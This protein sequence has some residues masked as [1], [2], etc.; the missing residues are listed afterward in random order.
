MT[1]TNRHQF[2]GQPLDW[3]FPLTF[4]HEGIP[5]GNATFG[6]LMWGEDSQVRITVNRADYWD[7]RGGITWS[8]EA[9]FTNLRH[10]LETDD[11]TNLR[12]VFEG[13]RTGAETD[14]P[15]P[16]RLPMGRVDL[17]LPEGAALTLGQLD[18]GT[19]EATLQAGAAQVDA[20][21]MR[22]DPVLALRIAAEDVQVKSVP[23]DAPEVVEHF[24]KYGFPPAQVED[25]DDYGCWTQECPGEPVMC[26]GWL[27]R[28]VEEGLEVLI[29]SV[30]G[31]TVEEA[32]QIA[33]ETLQEHAE[34]G[35][36]QLR[37]RTAA[38]WAG[39]W[40]RIA[41]VALPDSEREMLYYLGM[42][43]LAGLSVPGSP[44]ATLQGPWVEEYRLPPWQCDYHFNINVQEC[45]W[46]AFAGNYL[47]ALEPLWEMIA[48]WEP[49]LRENAR[50]FAGVTDG[51]QLPHAVDDRCTCMGGF[52]T[53]S[54]DHG[55][56]AWTGQLMWL[57]WRFTHDEAFL[58]DTC[59]PFLK[60]AMRVYEAMLERVD[61]AWSL[62]VSVSPE[63]GGA[64]KNAWGRNAS[65]QLANIHFLCA[66][67]TEA[68][69]LLGVDE[70]DRARWQDIHA[71]LP[72]ASTDPAGREIWLW[73]GQPLAES[74]RHHS[75]LAGIHPFEIFDFHGDEAHRALING[76][77]TTWTRQ[78][79]GLWSGWSMPWAAILQA[80]LGNGEMADVLLGI[81]RR[82]Y[83]NPGYASGHDA[84]FRGFTL[85]A[86]RPEIMQIEAT[87]AA[88]AAVL[89]LLVQGVHGVLRLF[90]AVPRWWRDVSFDGIRTDGAFLV[91]GRMENSKVQVVRIL[92]EAGCRL[93]LVNPFAGG[94]CTVGRGDGTTSQFEGEMLELE[95]KAGEVIVLS[96]PR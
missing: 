45:Y 35:Y 33:R 66:A 8:E 41:A 78:G 24:R 56:T 85:M 84:V 55:S 11:E 46:P 54:I 73:E 88:S 91:S 25:G 64:G 7:H 61:G 68:S 44:A 34:A 51:L 19:S 71:N 37:D 52:W 6:A 59:Y 39:Y 32:R 76:S 58:R 74:H 96:A 12:R 75:H 28:R 20:V 1:P 9:N 53:G 86:G 89:E 10:W 80:R 92:S 29:A 72:L 22:H 90:P 94:L 77:L 40:S 36:Q 30:Y 4:A 60:G 65:F 16:T 3:Y 38:W 57:Q 42:Y 17:T 31:A 43:K 18:L 21:L 93:R 27:K 14:P 13:T 2:L 26:V 82:C 67:L 87:L 49:R 69:E 23:P 48:R 79:M 63:Y 47:P 95:T 81:Y 50:V 62:P 5:L 83:L 15:R 70:T